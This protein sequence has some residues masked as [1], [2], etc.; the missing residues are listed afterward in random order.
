MA[1]SNADMG[2]ELQKTQ[3]S[4]DPLPKTEKTVEES[5]DTTSSAE[6][7]GPDILSPLKFSNFEL[8]HRVVLAPVTRCR[9]LN[10]VPQPAHVTFYSQRATRGGFLISEAAAVGREGIGFPNSPG[11][12]LE[13]QVDGWRKVVDAVHNKGGII[14]CQLWHVGRASHSV[15][16]P[17]GLAPV[18]STDKAIA[19]GWTILMPDGNRG[20]YSKPR[21][22]ET[23][24]IPG[25][26]NQFR[27][28]ARNAMAAGFDGVEIHSAHGYLI[29][30]FLKNGIND[31]TDEY[32]GS[33]ENRCRFALEILEAV[34]EE[35]GGSRTA[36]RLSPIIDHM[37]ATDSNPV[38]LGVYLVEQL[39]HLKEPLAYLHITEP[40]FTREGL[41]EED[42]AED[43]DEK[44]KKRKLCGMLR[45][46]FK[47]AFMSSGGFNKDTAIAAIRSGKADMI[48]FGRLFISNPDLPRRFAMQLKLSKYDRSTF[49][50]SEQVKG[51]TDYPS[52]TSPRQAQFPVF[53]PSNSF[54]S[55]SPT[56][57][58][59]SPSSSF[60]TASPFSPSNSI[61]TASPFSP[62]NS[63][64]SSSSTTSSSLPP[65]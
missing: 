45:K 49:Y 54:N 60:K 30:Q 41:K 65:K 28:A 29:D 16:Q 36:I 1:T 13:E 46:I 19:D 6:Y 9:A 47:G 44:T 58:S 27:L 14:F 53:S 55:S 61:K 8:A 20:D 59:F 38:A 2:E 7:P 11:I 37:G 48:S 43:E 5:T 23:A 18:S 3:G 52:F 42:E 32:G 51:Y 31:R 12:F 21:A 15:Y 33:I 40:R 4:S 62:S 24:E 39:N 57:S 56:T 64:K 22:L 17:D 34:I 10:N 63:F 26:V 50:S 35:I 25:I